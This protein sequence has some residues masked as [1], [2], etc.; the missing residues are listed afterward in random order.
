LLTFLVLSFAR[1]G[2]LREQVIALFRSMWT[3][4]EHAVNSLYPRAKFSQSV[5]WSQA[6]GVHSLKKHFSELLVTKLFELAMVRSRL[7]FS[8]A[9]FHDRLC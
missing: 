1:H 8:R 5:C 4:R 3:V 9:I 2:D 7:H 6:L